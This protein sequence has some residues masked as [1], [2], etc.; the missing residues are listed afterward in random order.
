M[1][2][3]R[4]DWATMWRVLTARARAAYPEARFAAVYRSAEATA[5]V[6]SLGIGAVGGEHGGAIAVRVAVRTDDFGTLRGT[7]A[8]RCPGPGRVWGWIGIRRGGCLA[9][10]L[11]RRCLHRRV[12]PAP[13]R[14]AIL[15]ADGTRLDATALGA[16]IAGRAGPN[17]TGLERI[18]DRRLG[19]ALPRSCCSVRG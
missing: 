2:W 16:S 15:A 4:G 3:S 10:V 1:A 8:C 13:Q 12:G 6:R 18:Y 17:P 11:V 14:A 19:G 5:S 9:C 7:I